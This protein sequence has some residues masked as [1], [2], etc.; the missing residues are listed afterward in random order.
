MVGDSVT[1]ADWSDVWMNEGWATW[2]E[3]NWSYSQGG[4]SIS[5]AQHFTNNYTPGT[6]WENPTA[7]P[8]A[9]G[10]LSPSRSIPGRR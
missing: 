4:S 2:S 5:P 3:W 9:A 6:K 7:T 8:T 10:I 1:P